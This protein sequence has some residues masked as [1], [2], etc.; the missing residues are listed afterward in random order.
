M[1]VSRE[2]AAENR[3][4][5]VSAAAEQFRAHGFDGIGVAD[6]MKA[7]GLTHGGF[8]G[9]FASKDDLAA[10]AVTRAFTDTTDLL[11]ERA[12]A[13]DDPFAT[14]VQ[15]YLSAV[16]RDAPDT[17]CAVA[18]LSQDAARSSRA[19]RAAFEA[20]IARY[21]G[22]IEELGGVSRDTAMSIYAA[23]VGGLTLA[24]TVLD[25]ALSDAILASTTATVLAIRNSS[26]A[27]LQS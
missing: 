9:N 19:L 22:L 21:L 3:E 4:R 23:M 15:I 12:L 25:P 5:V 13:S 20:G 1:R 24:R 27:P 8:Y 11:R 14:A 26:P 10:E 7:A 2:K 16:H 17:G 18:A 6:L